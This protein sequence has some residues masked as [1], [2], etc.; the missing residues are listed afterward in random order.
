MVVL[1]TVGALAFAGTKTIVSR[2]WVPE[3]TVGSEG[4]AA[5]VP[6]TTAAVP[7]VSSTITSIRGFDASAAPRVTVCSAE[8]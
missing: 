7:V 3:E 4:D 6:A 1:V 8:L 2:S 5:A